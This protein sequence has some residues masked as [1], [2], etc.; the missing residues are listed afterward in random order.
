VV[1]VNR[2]PNRDLSRLPRRTFR[3]AFAAILLACAA[4]VHACNVPVFRYALENWRPDSY[5]VTLFHRGPLN[6]SERAL[7]EPLIAEMEASRINLAFRTADVSDFTE[8]ED[9]QL[10]EKHGALPL[11]GLVVRYPEHLQIP[12]PVRS[13][14]L[15]LEAV[16]GLMKS[17]IRSEL[18]RRL[19]DGQT[20]V[21]LLL[22]TGERE[23]DDAT[24]AHLDG[25]LKKLGQILKLPEL[26]DSPEDTLRIGTPPRIEFSLLRVPRGDSAE[27][28][29]VAMLVGS[30][31]D[32]AER[33]EPILFPVFGRGRAL[34]PLVGRGITAE[35][36][37]N[38]A[39]FLV[40][41]C[42]CQVKDQNPGFDLLLA[43]DWENLLTTGITPIEKT[44][45]VS[46]A[47]AGDPEL[48]PI[49][50]G[51]APPTAQ[52]TAGSGPTEIASSS[53]GHDAPPQPAS[54]DRTGYVP[55]AVIACVVFALG[56]CIAVA[57]ILKGA[58]P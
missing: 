13:L 20:A 8:D 49:P 58:R 47:S 29:L 25:E 39:S 12:E 45:R 23:R 6:E 2:M 3:G 5:R 43:A 11:P 33:T 7:I 51:A 21:W 28:A 53:S 57:R 9:R 41:P 14:A 27:Q 50:R 15:S 40:G 46:A 32:L 22:E 24:A 56:G 10:F 36:I 17:A 31:S 54:I 19:A 38:S 34:L 26:T 16:T 48:V 1:I 18:V 52:R 30:E 42:S 4:V 55:Q 44:A 37:E 35:N